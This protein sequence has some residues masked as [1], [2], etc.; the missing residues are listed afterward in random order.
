MS[1]IWL[2]N[3]KLTKWPE[4]SPYIAHWLNFVIMELSLS[5]LLYHAI[6]MTI[7]SALVESYDSTCS[8]NLLR[9]VTE[10]NVAVNYS[11]ILLVFTNCSGQ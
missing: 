7:T 9:T 6:V 3:W 10:D 8:G 4:T 1:I 2:P 11:Y 5:L